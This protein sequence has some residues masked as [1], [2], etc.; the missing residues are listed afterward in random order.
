MNNKP[1]RWSYSSL[2]TYE[3]CPAKWKYS[4]LDNLPYKPSAAMVRGSRLHADCENFIK[5]NIPALPWELN[6]ITRSIM[7]MMSKGA[8]SEETWLLDYYW[9][10]VVP[11]VETWIKSIVD[12]HWIEGNVLQVR[13]FKSG[14]EYPDHREQ[15]ELYAI[16]GLCM[17]PQIERAEYGAVYLDT[18]HTSN[19]GAVLRG[20]MLDAKRDRWHGRAIK[21]FE[22]TE[23][24]ATP[25]PQSCRWCDYS[26][27]K[28]GP[29]AEG[30]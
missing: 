20:S 23:Y 21:L 30:V 9:N 19:E 16:K 5:G 27:K 18:G 14:R 1:K 25:N 22:D 29:C 4:Y 28:G 3:S 15:L 12:V 7:D 8:K 2:T 10:P 11:G 26:A 17:F 24:K 6:K 13:D